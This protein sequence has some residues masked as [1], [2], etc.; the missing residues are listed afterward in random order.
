VGLLEK[1]EGRIGVWGYGV[2]GKA[3]ARFLMTHKKPIALFD[4]DGTKLSDNYMSVSDIVRFEGNDQLPA[5]FKACDYIIPSPGIDLR[6]YA[7]YNNTY[8]SELDLFQSYWHKP[9]I[10]VTGS[11]GKTSI[12]TILGHLLNQ[13]GIKT[14]VGGNIGI[15]SLD[16]IAVQETVSGTLL[17]L[18]SFQ[19][20]YIAT[21]RPNIAIISNLSAN[22]LDRH[23]TLDDYWQAKAQ[24][25]RHQQETDLLIVDWELRSRVRTL[26]HPGSIW[27]IG[28]APL[29]DR[30]TL[31]PHEAYWY[32]T[33]TTIE[34]VRKFDYQTWKK[35]ESL[36]SATFP[37][38]A[39]IIIA[40][41]MR[42]CNND[43]LQLNLNCDT[44]SLPHRREKVAEFNKI[45]FINDSKATST[46]AMLAAVNHYAPTP[47]IL[48]VGGLSKGVD[49]TGIFAQL[50]TSVVEVVCFGK[51][52]EFLSAAAQNAQK[53]ASAHTTLDAALAHATAIATQ[54]SL[55]LL[56]P[57]G[58]S[59]D[60]Y[61]NYEERGNHFKKIVKALRAENDCR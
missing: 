57:A 56:S 8:I 50:P 44:L 12:T 61:A 40:T 39:L 41:L 48:L 29:S 37:Q 27:Y 47:T 3:V 23:G 55:I 6:P 22:H 11:V 51:E 10:G 43:A 18:S 26:N 54:G 16:L 5:F 1:I 34:F 52:A 24:I 38:N 36:F 49:R 28:G 45:T 30:D 53:N 19:L 9:I 58:S 4:T 33:E 7:A 21:F 15:G 20:E 14:A 17:E 32:A 25:V 35:P 31:L 46:I 59:F 2:V 13:N 42:L 60:L